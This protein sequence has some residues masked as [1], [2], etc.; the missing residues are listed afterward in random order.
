MF[1]IN[2]NLDSKEA[3]PGQQRLHAY[4]VNEINY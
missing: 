2:G 1:E 3:H 4:A